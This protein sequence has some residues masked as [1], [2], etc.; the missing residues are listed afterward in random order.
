VIEIE[1]VIERSL[2]T[3]PNRAGSSRGGVYI[4][5]VEKKLFV[6]VAIA[7]VS[8]LLI[9]AA[10]TAQNHGC[11]PW[12]EAIHVGGNAFSEGDRGRTVCR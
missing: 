9:I 4:A 10:G 12:K 6:A 5:S 7:A 8:A 3:S 1:A 2:V 11:L